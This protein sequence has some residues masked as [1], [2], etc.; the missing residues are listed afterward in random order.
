ML[1]LGIVFNVI[2]ICTDVISQ[3][4]LS[5]FFEYSLVYVFQS[6]DQSIVKKKVLHPPYQLQESMF[7]TESCLE[8]KIGVTTSTCKH[9]CNTLSNVEVERLQ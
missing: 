5:K 9:H 6:H 8:I 1:C 4:E 3:S 2:V 7:Q